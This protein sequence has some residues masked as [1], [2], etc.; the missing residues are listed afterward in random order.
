MRRVSFSNQTI[1]A[2]ITGT[3][4]TREI[5]LGVLRRLMPEVTPAFDSLAGRGAPV[6]DLFHRLD[7]R[8]L[9]LKVSREKRNPRNVVLTT[10]TED[11]LQALYRA[12][13]RGDL[14]TLPVLCFNYKGGQWYQVE[15]DAV[16]VLRQHPPVKATGRR[17]IPVTVSTTP[18]AC[19]KDDQG[20]PKTKLYY[21]LRVNFVPSG[22]VWEPVDRPTLPP[23]PPM[24]AG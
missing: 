2:M 12:I 20:R 24:V 7:E 23:E 21:P 5:P 18:R 10:G 11:H 19:G 14:E 8:L 16:S 13:R 9:S 3:Y 4:W 6:F 1:D 15:F 22:F 17:G